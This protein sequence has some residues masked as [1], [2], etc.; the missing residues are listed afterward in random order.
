MS[1]LQRGQA[2]CFLSALK[3][4][5]HPFKTECVYHT[6]SPILR[7]PASYSITVCLEIVKIQRRWEV[8]LLVH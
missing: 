8:A 4:C 7:E 2:V 5:F 1:Q 6:F 3:V